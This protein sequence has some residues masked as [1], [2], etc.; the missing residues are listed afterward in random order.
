VIEDSLAGIVA[1]SRAGAV[2][3]LVPSTAQIDPLAIE[4]CDLMVSDLEQLTSMIHA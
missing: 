1:A 4:L 3:V 2:T